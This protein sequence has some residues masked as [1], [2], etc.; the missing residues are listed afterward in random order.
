MMNYLV[1]FI[2]WSVIFGISAIG[3]FCYCMFVTILSLFNLPL[4][5]WGELQ[6]APNKKTNIKRFY[7]KRQFRIR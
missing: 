2:S 4:V 5:V 1:M 3:I 6:N 7:G